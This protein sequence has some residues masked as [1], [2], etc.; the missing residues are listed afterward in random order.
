MSPVVHPFPWLSLHSAVVVVALVTYVG[1]ALAR[2]QRRHPSAAIGWV[3]F[4][5]L[6]P[7]LALP[8]FL[9]F[10]TRKTT[11]ARRRPERPAVAREAL[12]APS[13]RFR[14]L[15]LGLG[16]P[17]AVPY[18]DLT[19]HQDGAA[20][21]ER[22]QTMML[23]ARETLEVA[24]F[25]LGRDPL[26]DAVVA[27]LAQR[28]R[29]GVRVRVMIDGVGRYLGGR[30][31][32]QPLRDAGVEVALFVRPWSSPLRGRV[33]L[34][35][36]RKVVI[37]DGE[38]L[39]TGGRNLAGEYFVGKGPHHRHEPPW[40]DLTFD[41]RGPIARQAREQFERD[42]AVARRQP[43]PELPPLDLPE[44]MPG[45]ALAQLLPSGPD[46]ADDTVYELLVDACFSAQ[47]RIVA[48]TPYF[49]PDPV[50]LMA[51]ALAARRGV[52][53]DL[54]VPRRS[55]H[56]LA[57]LARP[58]SLRELLAS[59]VRI[60]LAPAMLHGKLVIVDETVAL[61]GSLNLDERSLF[62]NYE[63][64][65]AFYDPQAIAR[66]AAWAE[67]AHAGAEAL[68]ARPVGALREVGEGLLRWLTF[69]L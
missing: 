43:V 61:A 8:L 58:G 3:L 50:L 23:A 12:Q 38:W 22:L 6:V 2:R 40:T 68:Q 59:G 24:S 25:L 9:L 7:Y 66:F 31:T 11:R 69:Q 29:E 5:V 48:V 30:P 4:L 44:P 27:L 64:M 67:Q 28:A 62:L 34:R 35:N 21:L 47:R 54:L 51:F 26:G 1:L 65:V 63:M 55:N 10:G 13:G 56:R 52:A 36:H 19:I 20:A 46:Q 49:V 60:W 32:L 14:A 45:A 42:W 17:P 33:N 41:L 18:E 37:V 39:W 15:A 16:L 53:V 57:D